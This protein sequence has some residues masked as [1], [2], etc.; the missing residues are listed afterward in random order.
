MVNFAAG[1]LVAGKYR[2]ER[3]LG[4]GGM[5]TVWVASHAI[6]RAK[7]A[8]KFLK[9]EYAKRLDVVH[10][11]IREAR[12]AVAVRHPN[13]VA[14]HDVLQLEDGTPAMVMDYL[15]GESL[16]T[17]LSREHKLSAETTAQLIVPALG[18]VSAAHALG[19]VHRDLK[20]DNLFIAIEGDSAAIKV[21][22]FGIAK[23]TAT[24]G[25]AATTGALTKTGSVLGTPYYMS[26]EQAFG[27]KDV[28]YKTD[29]WAFGIILYECL[30]GR[31]P[32][33]GDNLGQVFKIIATE[34]IA[35]PK[36][37]EPSIPAEI[38]ILVMQMLAKDRKART[39]SLNDVREVLARHGGHA[40]SIP[41]PV[42]HAVIELSTAPTIASE[43]PPT[44]GAASN[45]PRTYSAIDLDRPSP[46]ARRGAAWV[47][48][49]VMLGALTV[50]GGGGLWFVKMRANAAQLSTVGA[51]HSGIGSAISP[52][53]SEAV[54]LPEPTS[55]PIATPSTTPAISASGTL[56]GA[57]RPRPST[58][59][60][61]RGSSAIGPAASAIAPGHPPP[62]LS[63][64]RGPGG[65]VGEPAF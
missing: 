8:I 25:E 7:V 42:A 14:I 19:I 60:S 54:G 46:P 2:L 37:H 15:R 38:D 1:E 45:G 24:E 48:V 35:P 43:P 49:P 23:L 11:F 9:P 22:D 41:I 18:A 62:A 34:A 10:R 39:A 63:S 55:A 28:D 52:V 26:P 59:S 13:V 29:I 53:P 33:E 44:Q 61:A 12:A 31:R 36:S 16:A 3:V 32:T 27:E 5:G 47:A 40:T 58:P 4:E 50:A 51:P 64:G 21:L 56:A 6:T 20:P 65:L 17:K 57:P 30:T